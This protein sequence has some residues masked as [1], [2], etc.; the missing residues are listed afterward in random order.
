MLKD[1]NAF[2][3]HENGSRLEVM[4]G[5]VAQIKF[6]NLHCFKKGCLVTHQRLLLH[7]EWRCNHF[8][9]GGHYSRVRV[10]YVYIRLCHLLLR[11]MSLCAIQH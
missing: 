11:W 4:L 1:Y 3:P 2:C 10:Q 8:S 9:V 7:R 6:E 5:V